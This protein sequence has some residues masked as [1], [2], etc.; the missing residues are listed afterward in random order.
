MVHMRSLD[1][2]ASYV[3]ITHLRMLNGVVR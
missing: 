1:I 3:R 2:S